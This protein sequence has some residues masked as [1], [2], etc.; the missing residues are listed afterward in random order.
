MLDTVPSAT[1]W[2]P[3]SNRGTVVIQDGTLTYTVVSAEGALNNRI[4]QDFTLKKD[5]KYLVS[6]YF[7]SHELRSVGVAWEGGSDSITWGSIPVDTWYLAERIATASK[8]HITMWIYSNENSSYM[9]PGDSFSIKNVMVF[10]LTE[11]YGEGNE[12]ATVAEF[13]AVFPLKY[14][15]T[16]Y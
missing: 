5:H 16:N 3:V 12:P 7:K 6:L 1:N 2:L 8:D 9:H 4:T 13:R 10:D 11:M 14:Y 15:A